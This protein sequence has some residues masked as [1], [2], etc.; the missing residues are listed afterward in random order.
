MIAKEI[1]LGKYSSTFKILIKLFSIIKKIHVIFKSDFADED[2][3]SSKQSSKFLYILFESQL[4][5]DL[6][7]KISIYF[8]EDIST[9]S[10]N[11]EIQDL[12][13]YSIWTFIY[14]HYYTTSKMFN[15]I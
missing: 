14:I 8:K 7:N 5:N 9:T 15:I 3:K 10:I 2:I 12:C 6:K 1:F 13:M 11:P 4:V